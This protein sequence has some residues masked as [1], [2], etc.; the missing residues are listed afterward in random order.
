M[1]QN[2]ESINLLNVPK[3]YKCGTDTIHT[4]FASGLWFHPG[5]SMVF[6]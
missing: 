1:K 3:D 6:A 5:V 2:F 4:K